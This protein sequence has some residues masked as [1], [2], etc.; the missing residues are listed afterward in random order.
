VSD[1]PKGFIAFRFDKNGK[2]FVLD[3]TE[4]NE[5]ERL[6]LMKLAEITFKRWET[7][8]D[9]RLTRRSFGNS[10]PSFPNR[11]KSP[12]ISPARLSASALT[13]KCSR[14]P[15]VPLR[16]ASTWYSGFPLRM[17]A[18]IFGNDFRIIFAF[19]GNQHKLLATCW[20]LQG[21]FELF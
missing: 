13:E 7:E 3:K 18:R 15:V 10:R 17:S 12:A 1:I 11:S 21:D 5:V 16:L 8:S 2:P 9:Q 19:T 20:Q 14:V 6:A 4:G